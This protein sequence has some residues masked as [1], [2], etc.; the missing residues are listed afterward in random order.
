M[1]KPNIPLA[2]GLVGMVAAMVWFMLFAHG[3]NVEVVRTLLFFAMG[4]YSVIASLWMLVQW[5]RMWH[6]MTPEER[7]AFK[8]SRR[9]RWRKPRV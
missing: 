5:F 1:A 6:R 3:P 7:V 9:N 8:E 2:V 4:V